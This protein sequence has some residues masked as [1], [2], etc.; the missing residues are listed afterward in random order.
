VKVEA[1]LQP[2]DSRECTVGYLWRLGD[3]DKA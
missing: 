3:E 1:S 2:K